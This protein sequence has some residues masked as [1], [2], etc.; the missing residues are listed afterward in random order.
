MRKLFSF[1]QISAF[2]RLPQ[3]GNISAGRWSVKGCFPAVLLCPSFIKSSGFILNLLFA[4]PP[5]LV[6]SILI[7]VCQLASKFMFAHLL[8]KQGC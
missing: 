5:A 8:D 2:D 1:F 7:I 6:L 4:V 3:Q